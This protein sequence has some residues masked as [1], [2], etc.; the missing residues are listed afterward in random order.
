[1]RSYSRTL[2]PDGSIKVRDV[3]P[4]FVA[5]SVTAQPGAHRLYNVYGE[6][7]KILAVHASVGTAP[8]GSPIIIDVNINGATIFTNQGNRPTIP[9]GGTSS[10][11]V[12]SM[13]VTDWPDGAYITVDVDQVGSS[14]PGSALT[15]LVVVG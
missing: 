2:K 8:Q 13:N 1:M 7:L 4:F 12:A 3:Y 14:V 15:V 5:G 9:A 6:T 10:G 11:R